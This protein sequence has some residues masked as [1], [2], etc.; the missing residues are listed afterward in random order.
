MQLLLLGQC[1]VEESSCQ[2]VICTASKCTSGCLESRRCREIAESIPPESATRTLLHRCN[3]IMQLYPGKRE[4]VSFI[5]GNGQGGV[6]WFN[7]A[8][9]W[10]RSGTK[11]M[12]SL[13]VARL[14]NA[15]R[16]GIPQCLFLLP[17]HIIA[18]PLR[19]RGGGDTGEAGLATCPPVALQMSITGGTELDATHGTSES[20]TGLGG[21]Q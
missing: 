20:G 21:R 4:C 14:A 9:C 11:C 8:I 2:V 6:F 13:C 5:G 15:L 12:C 7:H 19:V 3:L 17:F 18:C 1:C 16:D 10:T